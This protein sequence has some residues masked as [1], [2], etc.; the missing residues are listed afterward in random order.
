[1][2]Y[3]KRAADMVITAPSIMGNRRGWLK[4]PG[5]D[6]GGVAFDV[7]ERHVDLAVAD[8]RAMLA[9]ELQAAHAAGVAEAAPKWT[10]ITDDK[11]TW[12]ERER[13]VLLTFAAYERQGYYVTRGYRADADGGGVMDD[14]NEW[15]S[16]KARRVYRR[17]YREYPEDA[18][19]LREAEDDAAWSEEE[20]RL[21]LE[22]ILG[23]G[24]ARVDALVL[25][26]L[27]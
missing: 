14:E 15:P 16:G 12:P 9:A 17:L 3:A 20:F 10:Q 21:C 26:V 5:T 8:V 24:P 25:E 27:A 7:G 19:M 18:T 4:V 1:V 13:D 23:W 6:R 2:D 22:N 11:A